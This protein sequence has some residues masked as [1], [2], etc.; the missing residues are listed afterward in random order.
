MP[1]PTITERP[2]SL[3]AV[4]WAKETTFGTIAA[5]TAFVPNTSCSLEAEP[6]WFSPQTMQG[7]R[8]A[9]VFNLYGEQKFSGSIE[10]PLFPTMGIPLLVGSIGTDAVTGTA[11]PYTHTI[12]QANTLPSFTI[13]KNIG[14]AQS[15]Q[16]AG[17][18]LGKYTLKCPAGNEAVSFTAEVSAQKASVLAIPTAVTT[19][20]EAPF[21][22]A[23]ATLS[24]FGNA[25]AEAKNVQ[26]D[27]DN[28][29]KETY[30]YSGNHGPSFITPASLKVSGSFDVVFSSL[31]DPIYGDWT[32]MMNGTL[33]ALSL[34][35]A[36]PT[37]GT[38]SVA[39]SLPQITLSKYKNDIKM[40]DVIVSSVNFEA[41]KPL[42]GA[43]QYTIQAVVINSQTAAY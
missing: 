3:S 39:I 17:C 29:L 42:T 13:E 27:I 15:L 24:L 31:N 38:G 12:S 1:F 23:E 43:N 7:T 9:Q 34:T 35:I 33:G 30:T 16:F 36:H 40:G 6:G 20:N 8:D 41:S 28:G 5:A 21:V 2:G 11:A 37:A 25:R 18:R 22:F 10:G 4:G 19:T 26:I 32:T 14:G